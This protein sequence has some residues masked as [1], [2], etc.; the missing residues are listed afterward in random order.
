[1]KANVSLAAFF[2][3][4]PKCD[5]DIA[6]PNGSLMWA[7]QDQAPKQIVCTGCQTVLTLPAKYA[8]ILAQ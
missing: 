1:M 8:R 7:I 5:T 3:Q 6:A 2:V 4:C